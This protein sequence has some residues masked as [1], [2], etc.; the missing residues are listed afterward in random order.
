MG[1]VG[2]KLPPLSPSSAK[3]V[4]FA[5]YVPESLNL[6]EGGGQATGDIFFPQSFINVTLGS[7]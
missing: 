2:I 5:K 7:H 1:V 6:L 3:A 4:N